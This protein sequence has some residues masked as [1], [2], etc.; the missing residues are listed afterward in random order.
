MQEATTDDDDEASI[1]ME[2]VREDP[3]LN[4]SFIVRRKA[5]KRT[6]PWDLSLDEL[7]LMSP[8]HAE[9]TPAMKRPRLE[10]P[11]SSST[12]KAATTMPSHD[13]AVSLPAAAAAAADPVTDTQPNAKATR[14]RS[15]WTAEEDAK[16]NSAVTNNREQKNNQEHRTNWVAVA[17][18]L[19][20]RP[21][22][23]CRMR[24]RNVL[25]PRI[26]RANGR[27]GK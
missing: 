8:P 27:T 25:D 9:D 23:Q 6:L 20:D 26:D 22:S 13:T 14:A 4:D 10:E 7:E 18:L 24:W 12:D 19:P 11:F 16:L 2:N 17:A 5:A 3:N 1:S 15:S 21:K